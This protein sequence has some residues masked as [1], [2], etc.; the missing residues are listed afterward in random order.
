MSFQCLICSPTSV[1]RPFIEL[2]FFLERNHL[3]AHSYCKTGNFNFRHFCIF[4][5]VWMKKIG[6]CYITVYPET[7]TQQNGIWSCKLSLCRKYFSEHEKTLL[8]YFFNLFIVEL[9]WSKINIWHFCWVKLIFFWRRCFRI[10]RYVAAT[11][12]SGYSIDLDP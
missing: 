7:Y 10:L 4:L 9:L 11:I 5:G 6:C 12:W 1:Y 8:F 2:Y 3:T